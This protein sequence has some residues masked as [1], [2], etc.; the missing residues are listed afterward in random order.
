MR[1]SSGSAV[2]GPWAMCFVRV[3]G[4]RSLRFRV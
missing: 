1:G 4:L 3:L 2:A